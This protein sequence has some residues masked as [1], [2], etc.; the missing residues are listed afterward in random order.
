VI[1]KPPRGYA[2]GQR[3]RTNAIF[4]RISPRTK[5]PLYGTIIGGS[6]GVNGELRVKLDDYKAPS[7]LPTNQV[8]L[9][10]V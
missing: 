4:R 1:I 9:I 10:D 8:E 3:F 6:R 2:I 7:T 5:C